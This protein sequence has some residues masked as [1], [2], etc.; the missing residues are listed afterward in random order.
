LG[1]TLTLKVV[2]QTPKIVILISGEGSN[3]RALVAAAREMS[4][5]TA[6]VISNRPDAAGISWAREQGIATQVVDHKAFAT[7]DD[8]DKALLETVHSFQPDWVLLAGFM[9]VLKGDFVEAFKG[10]LLNIHPSLLPAFPG[11]NTHQRAIDA[12]V[13][14]HG[15]SV[16]WVTQALDHGPLLRQAAI[17]VFATDTANTLA[18]RLKPIEHQLYADTLRSL[19]ASAVDH[20]QTYLRSST[21]PWQLHQ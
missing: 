10:R 21:H 15:A 5:D 12:G 18:A 16:H 4:I 13:S 1:R 8:F 19:L 6:A 7:R 9:R 14:L 2:L 11:L 17:P 20:P 3:M